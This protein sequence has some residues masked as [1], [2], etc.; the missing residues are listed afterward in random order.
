MTPTIESSCATRQV[1]DDL[2]EAIDGE[3]T[4][5]SRVIDGLLDLRNAAAGEELLQFR[6][7]EVLK[8]VPG[9]T[10]VSNKWWMETL[11]EL[12]DLG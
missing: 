3:L 1:I 10:T 6:I 8:D 4:S 9:V 7:D 11:S 12:A 5:H 2:L